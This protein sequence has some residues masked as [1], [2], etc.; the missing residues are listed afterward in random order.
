MRLPGI[1]FISIVL[2]FGVTPSS[3]RDAGTLRI[4]VTTNY[5]PFVYVDDNNLM[6]GFEIDI[7]NALCMQMKVKCEFV[8]EEWSDMIPALIA[9]R[10]DAIMSSMSIT[11]ERKQHIDF[12]KHYYQSPASFTARRESNI[13][14]TSPK[15]M[16]GRVI[17]A[18]VGTIHQR[19]AEE[20]YVPAGARLK[21]YTTQPEAQLELERGFVDAILTDKIGAYEWLTTGEGS[22]CCS[23][24]GEDLTDPAYIGE[25]VGV[26]LRKG[27]ESL[28]ARIND[29]I[30][31]IVANGTYR[32]IN[33]KYFPF[34]I[35]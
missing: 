17:G 12:S 32:K 14:D 1:A 3:A 29:A 15:G 26:G 18:T 11:K 23:Y 21:V 8:R 33:N 5:P 10:Y 31:A 4:G 35:Y 2:M 25:G 19:Y 34:R 16:A 9:N 7:A 22:K 28:K 30:D 20:V 24:A 6:Q 27:E 13:R